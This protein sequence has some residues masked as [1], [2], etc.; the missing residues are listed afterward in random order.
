MELEIVK[1]KQ[2][3]KDIDEVLQRVKEL[4]STRERGLAITKL[5]ESIMWLSMHLKEYEN[6]DFT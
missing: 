4:S 3:R 6:K 2:L 1:T 5:Q